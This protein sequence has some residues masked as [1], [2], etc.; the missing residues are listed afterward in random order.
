MH[1]YIKCSVCKK[2]KP[3]TEYNLGAIYRGEL[4]VCKDCRLKMKD[5]KEV[6]NSLS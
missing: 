5:K 2:Y 6:L 4:P 3:K 1:P